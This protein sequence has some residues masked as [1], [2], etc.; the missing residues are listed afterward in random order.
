MIRTAGKEMTVEMTKKIPI[1]KAA[2]ALF[3]LGAAVCARSGQ[4][5]YSQPHR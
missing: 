1:L 4:I 5:A 2:W 3:L